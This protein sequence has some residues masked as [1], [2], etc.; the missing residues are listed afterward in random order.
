M[1][2]VVRVERED[3]PMELRKRHNTALICTTPWAPGTAFS[4]PQTASNN[5]KTG[6]LL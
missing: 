5:G 3:E 4:C 1:F 6:V 2:G